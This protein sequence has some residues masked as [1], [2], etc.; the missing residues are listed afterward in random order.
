[1]TASNVNLLPEQCAVL[2]TLCLYALSYPDS[3]LHLRIVA[4]LSASRRSVLRHIRSR[5]V[6]CEVG[7]KYLYIV[8]CRDWPGA[9]V[10]RL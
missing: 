5:R 7:V 2:R 8:S 10:I 3:L 9:L 6:L 4:M 1:M